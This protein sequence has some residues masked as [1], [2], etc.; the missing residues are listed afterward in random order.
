MAGAAEP[1]LASIGGGERI[2][3]FKRCLNHGSNH[4]LRDAIAKLDSMRFLTQMYQNHL[5]FS[6]IIGID[7]TGGIGDGDA[8]FE[9]QATAR[10]DLPFVPRGD[11]QNPTGGHQHPLTRVN[12]DGL[13]RSRC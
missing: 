12:L 8:L 6:T 9:G 1:P 3:R 10:T 2:H 13:G 11:L 7:S 4:Q 5:D